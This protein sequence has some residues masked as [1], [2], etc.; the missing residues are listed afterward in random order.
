RAHGMTDTAILE[1]ASATTATP[2]PARGADDAAMLK[3]AANLTRDLNR[4]NPAIYWADMLG[5][6]LIGYAALSMA[7]L[8]R[9]T[10]LALLAGLAPIGMLIRFAILAPLS[11]LLPTLRREVIAKYSG[12]QINPKFRRP[13]PDGEF[14]RDWGWQES[15]CSLWAMTLL[16]LTAAGFIPLRDF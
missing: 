4:P 8:I 12:L 9:S 1:R 10:P 7:M 5:M 2:A 6:A 16:A 3:A 14:A 15:A 11:L 13:A